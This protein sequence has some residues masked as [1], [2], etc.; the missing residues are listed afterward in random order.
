[1]F[2]Y[3]CLAFALA[4]CAIPSYAEPPDEPLP[5]GAIARL[6]SYRF[7]HG[8]EFLS[9]V[10]SPNGKLLA[11]CNEPSDCVGRSVCVWDAATGVC[12]HRI[13]ITA[14]YPTLPAFSPDGKYLAIPLPAHVEIWSLAAERLQWTVR[15]NGELCHDGVQF[16]KNGR[17]LILK[18]SE[19][20]VIW[21]DLASGRAVR[22]IL[23]RSTEKAVLPSDNRHEEC[24]GIELSP[25]EKVL[26]FSNVFRT[27]TLQGGQDVEA[28]P[29][30]FIEVESGRISKEWCGSGGYGLT[31]FA[32]DGK[33]L[34][35]ARDDSFQLFSIDTGELIADWSKPHGRPDAAIFTGNRRVLAAY[36]DSQIQLIDLQA[37]QQSPKACLDASFDYSHVLLLPS[38]KKLAITGGGWIRCFDVA[39][40]DEQDFGPRN[41]FP[42]GHVSFENHGRTVFA[43]G[44]YTRQPGDMMQEG[45]ILRKGTKSE[46]FRACI[47][48][49]SPDRQVCVTQ[50][51]GECPVVR[52]ARSMKVVRPLE[53]DENSRAFGMFTK[54]SRIVALK[55]Q[56]PA[57]GPSIE[58]FE[59]ATGKRIGRQELEPDWQEFYLAAIAPD[60]SSLVFWDGDTIAVLETITGRIKTIEC[61]GAYYDFRLMGPVLSGDGHTLALVA[62]VDRRN[63]PTGAFCGNS[64]FPFVVSADDDDSPFLR[65]IALPACQEICRI[66]GGVNAEFSPD[67]K[68][69]AV[70]FDR[71]PHVMVFETAS[72]LPYATY[73][74]HRD[75]ALSVAFSP[76]GQLLATGGADGVVLLWDLAHAIRPLRPKM[77]NRSLQD[78]WADLLS[79]S[80]PVAAAAVEAMADTPGAVRFLHDNLPLARLASSAEFEPL[81]RALSSNSY[82]ERERTTHAISLYGEAAVPHLNKALAAGVTPEARRR[83]EALIERTRIAASRPPTFNLLREL[84]A[85][86]A[87]ERIG[88]SDA[89]KMLETLSSGLAEARL[90]LAAHDALARRRTQTSNGPPAR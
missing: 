57:E 87:L 16:S 13:A 50:N 34:A 83:M 5:D 42:V 19:C 3:P 1:M 9:I 53:C 27:K 81:I 58:L 25:D 54:D 18:Y 40:G 15:T 64:A 71:Q 59:I 82:T 20:R 26:V 41:P 62:R 80:A 35:L 89:K 61:P 37:D 88:T 22:E 46:H 23:G 77:S 38:A 47:C 52:D 12:L 55:S 10:A 48:A 73:E 7:Y 66:P 32:P 74:G 4:L 63:Q 29:L 36:A 45:T 65:I 39:T 24:Y 56:P 6:G 51:E 69:V 44:R 43:G 60:G 67:G 21:H 30:R 17:E 75:T 72:G 86:A 68:L 11:S 84:R 14:D 33:A 31:L 85:V 8:G 79:G 90:T 2:R 70:T 28:G 78:L 49:V 76:N